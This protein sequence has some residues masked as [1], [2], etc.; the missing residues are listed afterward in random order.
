[1]SPYTIFPLVTTLMVV[2]G[3]SVNLRDQLKQIFLV[4]ISM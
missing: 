4:F 1:M 3:D 2:V